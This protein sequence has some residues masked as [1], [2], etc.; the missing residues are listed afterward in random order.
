MISILYID[1]HFIRYRFQSHKPII[2][3]LWFQFGWTLTILPYSDL[4]LDLSDY[5]TVRFYDQHET[6]PPNHN[7]LIYIYTL[8]I[9]WIENNHIVENP[10]KVLKLYWEVTFCRNILKRIIGLKINGK[11]SHCSISINK[12]WYFLNVHVGNHANDQYTRK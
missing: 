6:S 7:S 1:I 2:I 10:C 5:N 4:C 12:Y 3:I 11:K 8:N 9:L